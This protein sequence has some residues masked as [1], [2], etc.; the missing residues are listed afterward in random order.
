MRTVLPLF[1]SLGIVIFGSWW[2]LGSPV[3]VA[4]PSPS[5]KPYCVSYSPFHGQQTPLELSTHIDV[6][7]IEED[8]QQLAPLTDCVR[9]YRPSLGLTGS[10]RWP[11]I[12]I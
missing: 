10:P 1:V 12:T 3:R 8:L 2:W 5:A 11:R 7:Q 9:T 4:A 6:S